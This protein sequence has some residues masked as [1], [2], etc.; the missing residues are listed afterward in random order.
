M[1]FWG[2][3]DLGAGR[4][5]E[6]C[7]PLLRLVRS[8]DADRLDDI[9]GDAVTAT[10]RQVF[11]SV[12]DG[13]ADALIATIADRSVDSF[14]RWGLFNALARLTF[15]G[16]VSRP[17]RLPYYFGCTLGSPPGLPGGGMTGVSPAFGVGA[18]MAGSTSGGQ[19]TPLV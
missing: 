6:L 17:E 9:F 13:N 11:I 15:D 10:F 18:F 4:R 19:M 7:G 3:H 5:T 14:A 8:A 12:F 16:L 1:L 2:V